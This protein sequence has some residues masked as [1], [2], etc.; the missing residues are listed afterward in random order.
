MAKVVPIGTQAEITHTVELQHTLAA[1]VEWLPRVLT[2][3]D[4]IRWMEIACFRALQP[5]CEG[6][7]TTVGTHIDVAHRAPTP[8]GGRVVATAVLERIDGRFYFMKVTARDESGVIGEGHVARAFVSMGKFKERAAARL[9]QSKP[10]QS[11]A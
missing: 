10:R 8:I 9:L 5:F 11:S 1:H 4:M 3:P 6:D 2:T 7:E